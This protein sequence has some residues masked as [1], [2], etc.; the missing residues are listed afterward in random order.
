MFEKSH[1]PPPQKKKVSRYATGVN[2]YEGKISTR[3]L[4]KEI[5]KS[6]MPCM[7][8][9]CNIKN[10]KGYKCEGTNFVI[11]HKSVGTGWKINF[12]LLL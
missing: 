3:N 10:Q 9:F 5:K 12:Y 8:P 2:W 1:L 7:Y 11:N 4:F 6:F